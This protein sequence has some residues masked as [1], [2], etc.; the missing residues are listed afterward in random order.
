MLR[1]SFLHAQSFGKSCQALTEVQWIAT[2][3]LLSSTSFV[4][5]V[6]FMNLMALDLHDLGKLNDHM[7]VIFNSFTHGKIH[8]KFT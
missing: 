6:R 2:N 8:S 7:K 4:S 1:H 3:P 5:F